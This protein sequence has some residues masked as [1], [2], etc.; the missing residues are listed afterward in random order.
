MVNVLVTGANGQL[1]SELREINKKKQLIA[2]KQANFLFTDIDT[3]DLSNSIFLKKFFQDNTI[4][5]VVN[6]AAYTN[7][8]KAEDEAEKAFIANAKSVD[9]IIQAIKPQK[10][11][12]I[13]ISTD[14]VFDGNSNIPYTEDMPTH[15]NSVYGKSKLDGEKLALE[16]HQS[17][18][19]RTSWLYSSF[20]KNFA[21]SMHQLCKEREELNVVFDQIG[22]PT[23]A[24]DLA[25]AIYQIIEQ[26]VADNRFIS[27]IYHYSNEGVCS[28]Y[29]FAKAIAKRSY[30]KC[31]INPIESKDYPTPVKRP[32]YSVLNKS[33][34]KSVYHI[35]IPHW[36]ESLDD[37]FREI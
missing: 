17:I 12:L 13:H 1:G 2:G 8:D 14:Y 7:V 16:Y 27:G 34:I 28:W 23:Y 19:I 5:F 32:F 36:Q 11:K 33:K 37:F 25:S 35:M 31:K 18:V 22:T 9:N 24:R 20:G 6:C 29:D 3:L 15:P 30:S 4:D 10:T 21:K 26:S